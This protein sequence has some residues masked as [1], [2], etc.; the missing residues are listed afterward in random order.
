MQGVKRGVFISFE[1]VEGSGKTTQARK[2]VDWL[3]ANRLPHVFVRDPGSTPVGEKIRE[4]LLD[5]G[6]RGMHAR[7]ELFL[8]L[9]ARS[10]LTYEK[11]LPALRDKKIVVTD[12]FA[13]STFAYQ[14]H[15]RDLP[16]RLV[17]VFN[18]FAAAGLKPDLTFLVDIDAAKRKERGK[19][20]D[21]METENELYHEKV[22]QGYRAIAG[23]AKK[24][25]RVIDGERPVEDL[26]AEIVRHVMEF[27][28]R[29]GYK[30]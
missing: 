13:D 16:G 29:K 22:R 28:T 3:L 23:R 6:S 19:F 14:S 4:V 11:I 2:L 5:K 10:Q 12:R 20:K 18:R 7:C 26:H 27:L 9:A 30:I 8:F 24:R 25:F 21:R 1:G 15:A 17:A